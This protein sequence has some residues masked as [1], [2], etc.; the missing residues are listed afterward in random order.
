MDDIEKPILPSKGELKH[1][2][3]GGSIVAALIF[4]TPVKNWF[5]TREEGTALTKS[6]D[7]IKSVIISE[8]KE[9]TRQMERKADKI[10]E[11][12]KE[13]ETRV[14]RNIDHDNDLQN[15][16]IQTLEAA[17]IRTSKKTNN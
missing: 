8:S 7:E 5:Y 13:S 16:R 12:L 3:V 14:Q 15:T 10:M 9:S 4:L 2:G 1:M 11:L 6:V 17:I